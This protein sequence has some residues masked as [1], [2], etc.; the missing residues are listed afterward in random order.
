MDERPLWKGVI[1]PDE[2]SKSSKY[3]SYSTFE[4]SVVSM[5]S[6]PIVPVCI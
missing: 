3:L 1:L 5:G 4:L 2:E 6:A